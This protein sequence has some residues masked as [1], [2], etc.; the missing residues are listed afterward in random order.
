MPSAITFGTIYVDVCVL[1]L[2]EIKQHSG[3]TISASTALKPAVRSMSYCFRIED[4]H[5]VKYSD[6]WF[7]K[8]IV[9][10]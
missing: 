7:T 6:P 1:V 2:Y 4:E 10:S 9:V 8:V 3:E 5:T